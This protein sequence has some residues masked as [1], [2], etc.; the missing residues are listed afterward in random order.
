MQG[1]LK[2]VFTVQGKI[3]AFRKKLSLR[4][5]YLA[6]GNLQMFT[7]FDKYM[8]EKDLNRQMVNIIQQH[9]QNILIFITQVT[10]ILGL[11][12]CG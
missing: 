11:E 6:E 8:G 4:Q 12:I 1:Q 2:D 9:L 10:K 3:D 5:T 7:N